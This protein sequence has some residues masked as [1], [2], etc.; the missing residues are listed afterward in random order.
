MWISKVAT[1]KKKLP[2][3]LQLNFQVEGEYSEIQNKHAEARCWLVM[4]LF[5][6]AKMEKKSLQ[7]LQLNLA[8][9]YAAYLRCWEIERICGWIN[10]NLRLPW[11]KSM[12][13]TFL[14]S[15][16][17]S[18]DMIA[19]VTCLKTSLE[20]YIKI[21]QLTNRQNICWAGNFFAAIINNH[22]YLRFILTK[23]EMQDPALNRNGN[24][25]LYREPFYFDIFI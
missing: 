7:W 10:T 15:G 12:P 3:W 19:C 16:L 1:I 23:F 2:Q 24:G 14:W 4:W 17:R 9:L 20:K 18:V 13:R 5:N 22:F 6:A 21:D 11:S 8:R 25:S